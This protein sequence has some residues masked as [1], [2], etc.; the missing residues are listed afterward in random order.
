M[1]KI[2]IGVYAQQPVLLTE[3]ILGAD[4]YAK[5]YLLQMKFATNSMLS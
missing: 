2:Q 1:N 3:K 4:I 5:N